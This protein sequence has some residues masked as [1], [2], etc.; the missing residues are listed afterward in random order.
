MI[1]VAIMPK[2][3]MNTNREDINSVIDELV[4]V[5]ATSGD[6]KTESGAMLGGNDGFESDD[7]LVG[8]GGS[9]LGIMLGGCNGLDSGDTLVGGGESEPDIGLVNDSLENGECKYE[10]LIVSG[11]CGGGVE[12]VGSNVG[13]STDGTT[14]G[15]GA[16]AGR[17]ASEESVP[18]GRPCVRLR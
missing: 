13:S 17:G 11:D 6:A 3:Q 2:K 1:P 18:G 16:G 9:E 4:L 7:S 8:D 12:A 14:D 10:G 15:V 5:E